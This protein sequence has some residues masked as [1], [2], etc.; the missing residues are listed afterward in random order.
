MLNSHA[1]QKVT[2][3]LKLGPFDFGERSVRDEET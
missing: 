3:C 1:T 2:F